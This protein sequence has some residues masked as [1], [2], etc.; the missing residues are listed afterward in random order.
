[1]DEEI[2]GT[3]RQRS[4]GPNTSSKEITEDR[5]DM[6]IKE[7]ELS[8]AK[9]FQTPGNDNENVLISPTD[10]QNRGTLSHSILV[11]EDYLVLGANIDGSVR[12]KIEAGD[13]INLAKLLPKIKLY[14]RRSRSFKWS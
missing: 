10:M 6:L 4:P 14:K 1:M 2:P 13:Y 8:K 7:A 3:L 11:D 12:E 9:M 5:A